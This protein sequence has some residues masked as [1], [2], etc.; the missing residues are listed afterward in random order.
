LPVPPQ[1]QT[2]VDAIEKLKGEIEEVGG[3]S[4][5]ELHQAAARNLHIR[6]QIA[7]QAQKLN[8]CILAF[9]PGYS[10]EVVVFDLT[11]AGGSVTLPLEG[12]LW[13][14]AGGSAY[15]VEH[16]TV[17]AGKLT[18]VH[19]RTDPLGGSLAGSIDEAPNP[20]FTG[21]LFR[22]NPFTTLPASSP[23]NP[24]GMISIV[25]PG[26]VD[27]PAMAVASGITPGAIPPIPGLAVTSVTPILGTGLITITITGSA[28]GAIP[29]TYTYNFNLVPTRD[30]TAV[31]TTVC[32]VVPTAGVIGSASPLGVFVSGLSSVVEPLLRGAVTPALAGLVNGTIMTAAATALGR[33]LTPFETVSMRRVVI[34]PS[35]IRLFPTISTYGP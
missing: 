1:C 22:S 9:G 23:A 21:P 13:R 6:Q 24:T 32:D 31:A 29:L 4:G 15:P 18:F 12:T 8:A 16:R 3:L 5:A 27:V 34:T 20:T 35:G 14:V 26:P 7:Q 2:F 25:I 28:F 10:T 33:P 19:G 11:P 17:Q 30:M